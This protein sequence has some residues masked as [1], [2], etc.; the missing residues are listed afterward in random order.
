MNK[1]MKKNMKSLW[2]NLHKQSRFRPKYPA[3][4]IVQFV[5]RNFNRNGEDKILDLGCGAG[6]HVYFMASENIDTY[7]VDIS[8]DGIE[9]TKKL[10]KENGLSVDLKVAGADN[11]PYEDNYFNGIISY[12]VLYYCNINEI[13]NAAKEIFRVLKPNGKALI[14]V[15]NTKDY[16]Y[17]K[18]KEIEKNTFLIEEEDKNKC[19]FNENG[20]IMH[21][22]EEDEV[23]K[24]FGDFSYVFIDEIVETHENKKFCDSNFVIQL[25]K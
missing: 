11:I 20:M 22:F 25:M 23:K 14:V 18:G 17:G 13:E 1:N 4:L 3:E 15:R 19:S 7:G 5:F 9:H 10:L 6:R 21:F 24:L 2:E 16:R 12:G 8:A